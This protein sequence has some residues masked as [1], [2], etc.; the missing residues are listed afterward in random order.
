MTAP[1]YL[2]F[3]LPIAWLIYR[4]RKVDNGFWSWVM[5][6]K[7]WFHRSHVLDLKLFIIG[8]LL[9][10]FNVFGRLSLTSVVAV[11]VASLVGQSDGAVVSPIILTV[12]LWLAADFASYCSHRIHHQIHLLW[13]LHAVHHSAQVLTPFTAYR[14]HPLVL[15]SSLVINSSLIGLFQGLLIGVLDPGTMI[16][17]IAGINALF[18]L[19]NFAMANF[20]HSHLWISFGPLFEHLVISPAQHQVHHSTNPKHFNKNYGHTLAVWDWVFGTLYIIESEEKIT[21][22]VE[23]ASKDKNRENDL[24]YNL[25]YPLVQMRSRLFPKRNDK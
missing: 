10:F 12:L 21:L 9:G 14:Q 19:A 13:P 24:V 8:R 3:S 18:V 17:T 25:T 22:G 20:H 1:E 15:V 5:P 4:F 23:D 2:L 7:I 11:G 16:V 6:R